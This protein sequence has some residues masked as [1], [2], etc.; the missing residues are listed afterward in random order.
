MKPFKRALVMGILNVTPDSFFDGGLYATKESAIERGLEMISQGADYIDV[1][2]ESSRP[3]A[4]PVSS[5]VEL[6]RVI[7]VIEG[8]RKEGIK[9]ISIDTVKSD[10]AYSAVKAGANLINDISASLIQVASELKVGYVIMHMQGNPQ[11]MQDKPIYKSVVDDVENF[12]LSRATVATNS[13]INKIWIDPGIGF[14]KTVK[15]NLKLLGSIDRLVKSDFPVLIGTS[16]KSF[17]GALAL[18][19]NGFPAPVDERLAGSLASVVFALEKGV[20]MV[21]VHDVKETVEAA[22]LVAAMS[23]GVVLE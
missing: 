9:N 15:Q 22:C 1:G 13:G 6:E 20:S 17:I 10:V 7:P 23:E 3:G 11:I 21:R 19:T 2:G 8:L 14:G 16:R 4:Q 18:D 12:L 5:E